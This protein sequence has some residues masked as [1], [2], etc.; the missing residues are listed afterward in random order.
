MTAKQDALDKKSDADEANAAI[1][2]RIETLVSDRVLQRVEE[3]IGTPGAADRVK[4][5]EGQI[6]DLEELRKSL[7]AK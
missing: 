7:T 6:D 3:T 1:D 2:R 5:I 4:D